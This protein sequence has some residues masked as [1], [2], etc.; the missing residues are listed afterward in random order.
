MGNRRTSFARRLS[1]RI[2]AGI[3]VLV[4]LLALVMG[5]L[6]RIMI[7]NESERSVANMLQATIR[8]VENKMQAAEVTAHNIAWVAQQ[9][10]RNPEHL[11]YITQQAVRNNPSIM[12]SAI[13][14]KPNFY[15][16]QYYFSPYSYRDSDTGDVVSIQLGNSEY[17]YFYLDWYQI[18]SL[19]KRPVWS[20]P[21]FDEGG[22]NQLMSTYSTPLLDESGEVLGMV[23]TDVSL[24]WLSDM[25][26]TIKPYN[27]SH[28]VLISRNGSFVATDRDDISAGETLIS[29]AIESGSDEIMDFV[30]KMV[31]GEKGMQRFRID[32]DVSFAVFDV[33]SNGW[34][35]CITCHYSD[36][37]KKSTQMLIGIAIICL[38]AFALLFFY[39]KR[40]IGKTAQPILKFSEVAQ[41][42]A[43]G[44]FDASLPV[45]KTNDEIGLLRDSFDEMR[46]SLKNYI[47]DLQ[48]TTASKERMESEL[49]IGCLIQ[50]A[51]SPV[52]FPKNDA[53]D[54]YARIIPAREVGGDL[55][56]FSESDD[57]L[58][59]VI[60]DVSGKGVPAAMFMA[61]TCSSI[62]ITSSLGLSLS[63]QMCRMNDT[64]SRDNTTGMFVTLFV[65]KLD[66]VTGELVYC[67]CGHNP[68]VVVEPGKKPYFLQQKPNLT[69]GIMEDFK[70]QEQRTTLPKGTLL[71]LYTDGVTEAETADKS[72]FGEERLLEWA[73]QLSYDSDSKA[74][75][76]S[77]LDAVHK[78]TDGNEQ[79]DDITIMTIKF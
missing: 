79:N 49:R 62:R 47:S 55:Y 18:P 53:V 31:R 35:A 54:L 32:N 51:M 77:L 20:E 57:K 17:D 3:A 6:S 73:A 40:I 5:L 27:N 78:F 4:V 2:V 59:F 61:L 12:G 70:Y 46:Q 44:D 8:E 29:W 15:E 23:T 30:M 26:S 74:I 7:A 58:F 36:V 66:L 1:R 24:E 43:A 38:L 19:L 52:R 34:M 14:L 22:G 65:A 68:L 50:Q 28:I 9:S 69:I 76:D 11:Y 64:I 60:G 37:L 45:I 75:N 63:E 10:L 71:I 33:L 56:D 67:N 42:V 16:G 48:T 21:Y 25:I 13:A 41:K 72:Q 39:S